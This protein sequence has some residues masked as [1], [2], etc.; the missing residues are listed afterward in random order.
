MGDTEGKTIKLIAYDQYFR[1][2][3]SYA[4]IC[5]DMFDIELIKLSDNTKHSIKVAPDQIFYT[6][7]DEEITAEDLLDNQVIKGLFS[8]FKVNQVHI[9][10]NKDDRVINFSS[11][12]FDK[13]I[14]SCGVLTKCE[15]Q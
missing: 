11:D 1:P 3:T 4:S 6:I 12:E 8:N 14:L 5:E 7:K 10:K 15:K 9:Y 13:Y 2:A